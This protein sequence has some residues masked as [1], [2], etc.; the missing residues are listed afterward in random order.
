MIKVLSPHYIS[1][2]FENQTTSLPCD[3]YTLQIYV[4]SGLKA[5]VPATPVYEVIKQNYTGAIT[6]DKVNIS[7]LISDTITFPSNPN[8][9]KLVWVKTQVTYDGEEDIY[10]ELV[11]LAVNGYGYGMEGENPTTPTN[12]IFQSTAYG[13]VYRNGQASLKIL[14]NE[15]GLTEVVTVVSYP[16]NE[17]DTSF[18]IVP[19][20]DSDAIIRHVTITAPETDDYI[21]FT[22]N[23]D[24][25]IF[26]VTDEC[27]YTPVVIRFMN[28]EGAIE[29]VTLFKA[30]TESLNVTNEEYETDAGQPING[31]HQYVTYNVQGRTSFKI[32]SGF[33]DETQN[34][35]FRQLLL[36][37][38]IFA[39]FNNVIVPVT[40]KSKSLEYKTRQKDRLINYEFEFDYAVNEIN[41]L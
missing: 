15:T 3:Y 8:E 35:T 18:N 23:G 7:R 26:D 37:S 36:S 13:Q 40:I 6:D 27:R 5:S 32:N 31:Y 30:M 19:T 22:F 20:T 28:K 2:S 16:N 33:V 1:T 38:K 41:N 14:A 4:W 11:Q 17:R 25:I 12:R 21:V 29:E 9:E 10:N 34:E 24:E 39:D